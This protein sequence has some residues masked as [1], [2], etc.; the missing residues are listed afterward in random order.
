MEKIW[1]H[2]F[3]VTLILNRAV[4]QITSVVCAAVEEGESNLVEE[5]PPLPPPPPK[6]PFRWEPQTDQLHL[7]LAGAKCEHLSNHCRY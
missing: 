2:Y 6:N 7:F 3:L 5:I 4:V 1:I